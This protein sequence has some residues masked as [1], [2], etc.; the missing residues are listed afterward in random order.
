M[1][2][3]YFNLENGFERIPK[4]QLNLAVLLMLFIDNI[5]CT[6]YWINKLL[7]INLTS[8]PFV[9]IINY[10]SE[11][12]PS[13][14][15]AMGSNWCGSNSILQRKPRTYPKQNRSFVFI[16]LPHKLRNAEMFRTTLTSQ[17]K[18]SA[19][20]HSLNYAAILKTFSWSRRLSSYF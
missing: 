6:L 5:K 10:S 7:P 3:T 4:S 17:S 1:H 11:L 2:C 8:S 20:C 13:H 9:H 18:V 19:P 15:D 14:S 16:S 12:L